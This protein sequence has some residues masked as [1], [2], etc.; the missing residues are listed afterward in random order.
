[1]EPTEPKVIK[2]VIPSESVARLL[3]ANSDEIRAALQSDDSQ[4][5]AM[6]LLIME[7]NAPNDEQTAIARNKVTSLRYRI[8]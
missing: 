7:L 1:M 8:R 5:R 3:S 4:S 6:A 2:E